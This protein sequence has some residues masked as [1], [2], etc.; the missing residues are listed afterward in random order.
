VARI[1]ISFIHEE[2]LTATALHEFIDGML[3]AKA[4]SFLS[5]DEF[6]V[7]AGEEWFKRIIEELEAATVVVLV[8]SKKSVDRPWVNFEAGAAWLKGKK[9]IPVCIRDMT[10][11]LLP[12]PYSNLQAV[13]LR[14]ESGHR[15]LLRSIAHHLGVDEPDSFDPLM[16]GI[17]V[18][19]GPETVARIEREREVLKTFAKKLAE[20]ERV[21]SFLER[22][23]AGT[24][25]TGAT[26]GVGSENAL[27]DPKKT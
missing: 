1:F 6:Q 24:I 4:G 3:G 19:G 17:A 11:G 23:E 20:A 26:S 21:E 14:Y 18:L 16:A 15:Y 25:P 27:G 10:P 7:Y 22:Y 13:D 8:L 9:V 2:L 5:S 12:K